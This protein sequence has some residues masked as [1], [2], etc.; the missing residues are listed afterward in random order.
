[1]LYVPNVAGTTAI[2][3]SS[4]ADSSTAWSMGIFKARPNTLKHL[5]ALDFVDIPNGSDPRQTLRELRFVL[6]EQV[7]E[8]RDL[9]DELPAFQW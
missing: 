9:G 2:R 6:L 7:H 4:A 8:A 3:S 1:M 5:V